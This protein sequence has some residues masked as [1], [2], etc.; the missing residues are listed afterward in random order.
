MAQAQTFT[1][2]T[3]LET[4][5]GKSLNSSLDSAT[6]LTDTLSLSSGISTNVFS[7]PPLL[8]RR[9][10]LRIGTQTDRT[11]VVDVVSRT[12]ARVSHN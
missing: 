8:S 2:S 4:N 10:R 11:M 3:T 5:S 7:Q 12:L 9:Y 1:D 6:A